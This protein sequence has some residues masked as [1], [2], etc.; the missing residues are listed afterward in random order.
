MRQVGEG[1][2]VVADSVC[3]VKKLQWRS[4]V[5]RDC[6]IDG[7]L[8]KGDVMKTFK[9]V[10]LLLCAA[11][12]AQGMAASLVVYGGSGKIGTRIVNEALSRGHTVTV[13][14]RS[15]DEKA[16][17]ERLNFIK[18]DILDS[19]DVAKKIT[20][21]NVLISVVS[22]NDEDFFMNAAQSVIKAMNSLGS[23]SPRLIWI[24]G[25]SSLEVEPGKR[26]L[27]TLSFAPGQG[28]ARVGH[29]KVLDYFRTLKDVKWTFVSPSMQISPGERTGKFRVGGDQLLKDAQGNSRISTE[30]FA[31]AVIDEVEKAEQIGKRFTVGY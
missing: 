9:Y 17:R 2:V 10:L 29:T 30:D 25:A 26:L 18:G 6:Y 7:K 5:R 23:K 27:D 21:N 24:G 15:V 3:C 13:V 4:G 1:R 12:A 31:V 16:Q 14:S 19:V 20:G 11:F 28:G 22:S 8:L